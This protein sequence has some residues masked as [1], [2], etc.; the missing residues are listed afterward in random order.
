MGSWEEGDLGQGQTMS[1]GKRKEE[2]MNEDVAG[3]TY[4]LKEG[5][6][7]A[8]WWLGGLATVKATGKETDGR[9]TVVEVLDPEDE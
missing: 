9:Y 7:E 5:E 6:G 2:P 8:R 4:G 1:A 3:R